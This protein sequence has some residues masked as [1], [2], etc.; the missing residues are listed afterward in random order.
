MKYMQRGREAQLYGIADALANGLVCV[1]ETL[2]G[3][4]GS[5]GLLLAELPI[6][7]IPLVEDGWLRFVMRSEGHTLGN[8]R[9]FIVKAQGGVALME[10]TI[11][12]TEGDMIL[13]LDTIHAGSPITIS[14]AFT[15]PAEV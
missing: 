14:A 1:Y 4:D 11:G 6:V 8:A 3:D 13:P 5:A 12:R 7:G 2:P 10:G 15:V 9:A